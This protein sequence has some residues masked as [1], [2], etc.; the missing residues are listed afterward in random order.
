MSTPSAAASTESLQNGLAYIHTPSPKSTSLFAPFRARS[1][2]NTAMSMTVTPT[3]TSALVSNTSSRSSP[4]SAFRGLTPTIAVQ[5]SPELLAT[6]QGPLTGS[7]PNF[8][9]PEPAMSVAVPS[10]PTPPRSAMSE[11]I[12]RNRSPGIIRRLSRGAHQRLTR[13]RPSANRSNI[14]DQSAGPVLVRRRSESNTEGNGG[15]DLSDQDTVNSPEDAFDESGYASIRGEVF[16]ALGVSMG[17]PG[18]R[19]TTESG[20]APTISTIL[21]EGTWVY[22]VTK[23]KRKSVKL[24][25]DSRAAMICWDATDSSKQFH[26]DDV[27]DL[28]VGVDSRNAREDIHASPGEERRWLTVVYDDPERRKGRS[29]KTMHLIAPDDFILQLWIDVLDTVSRERTEIMY[30]LSASTERSEK[31]MTMLWKQEMASKGLEAD[32]YLD[33]S[34]A[35]CICRKLE[36]NCSEN[37]IRA[38]FDKANTDRSGLLSYEQYQRFIALF[39][40]R[41]DMRAI[42]RAIQNNGNPDIDMDTF[43]AFMTET[44]G[45]NIDKD[46]EHWKAVFERY[47]RSTRSR[48][49]ASEALPLTM[50]FQA[51]Q[52]F[53]SSPRDNPTLLGSKAEPNLNRPLNEYFISSSHNTYLLGRQFAGRSSVEAY[54]IAL[55]EGC[56]C[57]EIDCWDGKDDRPIVNHG[58]SMSTSVLFSDVISIVSKH[59]FQTSQYPLIVSLEVHCN[60]KQQV[61]MAEEMIKQFGTRLVLQP[62]TDS[63]TLPSPEALKN[64]ILIK[65]KKPQEQDD[66]PTPVELA[67][68]RRQRS[69]SSPFSRAVSLDNSAVPESPLQASP[70]SS[71]PSDQYTAAWSTPRGS[72]PGI[73]VTPMS[74]AEDS[75]TAL[76]SRAPSEKRKKPKT[77]KIVPRLGRLGVYTQG[78]TFTDFKSGEAQ[79]FNHV[80]SFEEN[81]F[82]GLCKG[83]DK[84]TKAILEKHNLRHL[85]RVYPGK[86]RVNSSNF[87]PLSAWRRGVQMAALN[88]QTYDIPLQI[89]SAMFAA[90][91]DRF[92]Y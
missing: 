74:S 33:L 36:I 80:F 50:N 28:R 61:V 69:F 72:A 68:V 51:F 85:M 56:R 62:I 65:V 91:N 21:E 87:D 32:Q 12:S 82:T 83:R 48:A 47:A 7:L 25:L 10:A 18:T 1:T 89:N 19:P 67:L 8:R 76:P 52:N 71:S 90:G 26:I 88:W 53:L 4:L 20:I 43:F 49:V 31:S 16:S 64:R 41:R 63:D 44:Q 42:F 66:S 29:I 34:G 37:A 30:A 13:R 55:L 73:A 57:I 60:N 3:T 92:G 75:D 77:S 46:R 22:K 35:K 78:I 27:R 45:A 81:T 40:E 14:R 17:R 84:D 38:R 54:V 79:S 70:L 59:A 24:R 23:K 9:L 58:Y 39:K 15:I 86:W 5:G 11:A 6:S 2:V